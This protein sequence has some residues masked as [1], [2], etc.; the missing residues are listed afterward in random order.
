MINSICHRVSIRLLFWLRSNCLTLIFRSNVKT[1]TFSNVLVCMTTHARLSI[2]NLNE[3][4]AAV[5]SCQL[6]IDYL[7]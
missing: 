1:T 2:I 4:L 7:Y 6:Y 3:N 5:S